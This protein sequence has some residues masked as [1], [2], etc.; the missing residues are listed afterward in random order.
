MW[1]DK[2]PHD[3]LCIYIYIQMLYECI[4]HVY[5][6][7]KFGIDV[8]CTP[9]NHGL[10]LQMGEFGP[11]YHLPNEFLSQF[12]KSYFTTSQSRKLIFAGMVTPFKGL[13]QSRTLKQIYLF[14]LKY[15]LEF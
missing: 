9:S 7:E 11:L 6:F 2:K 4:V 8:S 13:C 3:I 12:V 1:D 14:G 15:T 5:C 10:E